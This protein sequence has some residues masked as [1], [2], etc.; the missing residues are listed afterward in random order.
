MVEQ[1]AAGRPAGALALEPDRRDRP[2]RARR[3][4]LHPQP[5]QGGAGLGAQPRLEDGPRRDRRDRLRRHGQAVPGPD[6]HPAAAAIQRDAAAGRGRDRAVERQRRRRHPDP[7]QPVAQ[8]PRDRACWAR[9]ST[10]STRPTSTRR[11]RSRSRS[12]TTCSKVIVTT[13]NGNP[14]YVRNVAQV[15][16][17]HRP[18][19]G[20]VGRGDEDDVV[21]GI[22]LMRKY[23]KSLPV[24]EAVAEKME[25]IEHEGLLPKGMHLKVFNQRTDLV[26]VTTHNVLHNL[27]VGMAL[28]I[29]HPV[30][31]P[32]RPGQRG[33]RGADDPAGPALLGHG[34]LRAGQVGQPAVDR[35]GRLRDHRRQLGDHRRE[36]LPPHHRARRRPDA[37]R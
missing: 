2:L 24:S 36:H 32:G 22:V 11:S 4:G 33:D 8:R 19:L 13:V 16:V 17:G 18:R 6:R 31:L 12:S 25:E 34:A 10:R 1:P 9:G 15:V 29:A 5:A 37:G 7:G 28:V 35:R 3:A 26:H 27:V 30:R 20:I 21:E 23:E 14:I